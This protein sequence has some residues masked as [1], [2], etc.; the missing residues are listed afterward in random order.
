MNADQHFSGVWMGG[1]ALHKLQRINTKRRNLPSM[2]GGILYRIESDQV[3]FAGR[4][5]AEA[6][7]MDI[8]LVV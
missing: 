7:R 2:H 5:A 3:H 4:N 6:R 8:G 1:G